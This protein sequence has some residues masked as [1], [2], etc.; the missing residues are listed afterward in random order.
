MSCVWREAEDLNG[1]QVDATRFDHGGRTIA[2]GAPDD[3]IG[4]LNLQHLFVMS[5]RTAHGVCLLPRFE[6]GSHA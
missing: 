3:K 1:C 4:R 5:R 2:N 6:C